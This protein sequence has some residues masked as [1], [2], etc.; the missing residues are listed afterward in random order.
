[1]RNKLIHNYFGV[2]LMIVWTTA[3]EII[4]LFKKQIKKLIEELPA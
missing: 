3:V 4:P 1:M 2:D